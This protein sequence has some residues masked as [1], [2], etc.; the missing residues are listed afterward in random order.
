MPT[1]QEDFDRIAL[2][3]GEGWDH[4]SHYHKFLLSHVRSRCVRALDVGCGK[5]VFARLLAERADHV[6]GLDFSPQ[7]IRLARE[8]SRQ[9]PNVEFQIADATTWN[10]PREHFDCIASLATF[11]HLPFEEMLAK[12]RDAL[13]IGGVLLI[14]DLYETREMA[15]FLIN[16]LAMPVHYGLR[17]VRTGRLR[18]RREAREAWKQHG[19]NDVYLPLSQV[20]QLCARVLPD[21]QVRRHLLWRYSIVWKKEA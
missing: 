2:V 15:D 18:S 16:A 13:K 9:H 21:A 14:L 20:R 7:M 11:H 1:I 8:R 12:M 19:P 4:N 5:G 6:L 3:S 10:F 17:L